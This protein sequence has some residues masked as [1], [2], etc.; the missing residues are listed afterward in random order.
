MKTLTQIL[1]DKLSAAFESCGYS[2]ELGAVST[3]DRPDLC[4]FQCNGAFAGA[5]LYHKAPR[6]IASDVAAALADDADLKKLEVVGA[7]FINIDLTDAFILG[8]VKDM[9][10]DENLGIPQADKPETI[11]LD[12][13]G[14]NVAKPLHIGH[15]RPAII[16]EALKRLAKATG[17]KTVSDVHLGDWGMPIGLVIAELRERNPEWECFSE[18][19]DPENYSG[20]G[21]TADELNEIYPFASKKSKENEE[22]KLKAR[23]ITSELQN[24]DP[25]YMALWREIT[26]ISVSDIKANYD[27]LNVGFDL[28]YG[29]SNADPYVPELIERLTDKGLL[30]ESDG[31]MVVDVAEDTDKVTIPPVIIKKSDNSNIYATTDLATLIQRMRDFDP[32]EVWYMVDARQSLHFTQVFRCAKKAGIV[33]ENVKLEHLANG[34]MNGSDGKPYKTRDGGVMRLS[35]FYNTVYEAAYSRVSESEFSKDADREDIARKIA[36]ATIKF[37]DLINHRMKDYVFE[38]DKFMAADGKTGSFLLYTIA[39][40]NSI[41]KKSGYED[42]AAFDSADIYTDTERDMLLKL[43]LTGEAFELAYR[44]KAPNI[45]CENAYQLASAFSKFYHDN[46]ILTEQDEGKKNAWLNLCVAAKTMLEKHL[47]VLG[48][49]S[50][51]MM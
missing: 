20:I 14:P 12:Y 47:D 31:A 46:H 29:E 39:R 43:A 6:M 16:G 42:S 35:E 38:L 22:F 10:A 19:F 51:E 32:D 3:S 13:G 26:N 15:L 27:M 33:P 24:G 36:V 50:V 49:E 48:I 30:H 45:V 5:K 4:Q 40:V 21:I 34:T 11:V 44:D 18:N 9:L 2:P 7:G 41:L 25:A 17:R 23:E 1:T 37:G 8:Y 28:W